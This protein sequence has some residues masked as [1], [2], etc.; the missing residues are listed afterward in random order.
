MSWFGEGFRYRLSLNRCLPFAHNTRSNFFRR[1]NLVLTL[2]TTLE[3]GHQQLKQSKYWMKLSHK[4]EDVW[5]FLENSRY[6]SEECR[7]ALHFFLETR[8]RPFQQA[9]SCSPYMRDF[10][11]ADTIHNRR[12]KIM[13][14]NTRKD[15]STSGLRKPGLHDQRANDNSSKLKAQWNHRLTPWVKQLKGLPLLALVF[16]PCWAF[17]S[18]GLLYLL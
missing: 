1:R 11:A 14:G 12:P 2:S 18:I 8:P 13:N 5:T 3:I 9:L 15:F 4:L 17:S 16:R 6:N 7:N 10:T